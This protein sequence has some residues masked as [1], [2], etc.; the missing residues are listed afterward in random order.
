M[1]TRGPVRHSQGFSINPYPELN[2]NIKG[3]AGKVK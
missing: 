3:K 1:E 2:I